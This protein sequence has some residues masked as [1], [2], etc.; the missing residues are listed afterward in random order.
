MCGGEREP[1]LRRNI[2]TRETV[3]DLADTGTMRRFFVLL[4]A[5]ALLFQMSWAVAAT[6]CEH[7]T[8]PEATMHFGHHVHVHKSVD[9]KKNV[10]G[11]LAVDDDCSYCHAGHAALIATACAGVAPEAT[12]SAAFSPPPLPGSAPA[13]APDRPQWLRLA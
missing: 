3:H 12:A 13:R 4:L 8:S 11:Q 1:A 7:E 10:A 5:S 9:A 6:Y 2:Y